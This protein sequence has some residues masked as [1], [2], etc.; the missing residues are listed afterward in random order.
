MN[1]YTYTDIFDT[2]GIEYIIIIGFLVLI[3]LFWNILNK[4]LKV[5]TAI[6][7]VLGSLTANILKTPRGL[8]Y[9]NNHTWS[10]LERSGEAKVGINELL[11][12][13]TGPVAFKTI[14]TNGDEIQKGDVILKIEQENKSVEISSPITGKISNIN[15]VV[16]ENPQAIIEDPY[17]KSWVYQINPSNWKEDTSNYYMAD[18]AQTW[19]GKEIE[20]FKDFIAISSKKHAPDAAPIVLQEGG[21]LIDNPLVDMSQEIW[22]D[23]QKQFLNHN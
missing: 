5:K 16:K 21:E 2:K 14:K 9:S 8:S 15:P 6:Q 4:P 7:K 1:S 3:I 19:F 18:E 13:L 17:G 20:R 11:L 23:F 12:H 22:V 10:H